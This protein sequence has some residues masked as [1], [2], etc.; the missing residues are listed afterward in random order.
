M[1]FFE[2]YVYCFKRDPVRIRLFAKGVNITCVF[3]LWLGQALEIDRSNPFL[4]FVFE[5]I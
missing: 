2:T 5:K 3:Q 4:S 1:T